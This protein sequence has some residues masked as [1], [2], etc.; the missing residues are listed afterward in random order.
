MS[1]SDYRA[2]KYRWDEPCLGSYV[3]PLRGYPGGI[4]GKHV[5]AAM[6]ADARILVVDDEPQWREAIAESLGDRGH[7]VT[8]ANSAA[9]GV[10]A[11]QK[12]QFDGV[13]IDGLNGDWPQVYNTAGQQGAR[14]LVIS[15]DDRIAGQVGND[16]FMS[17][18]H[19]EPERF[20][21]IWPDNQ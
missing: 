19:Y 17:K 15:G 1:R 5:I 14:P 4:I 12:Q 16:N 2:L 13:T 7:D 8:C 21:R 11:L 6:Q 18:G 9:E 10:R 3:R 20:S